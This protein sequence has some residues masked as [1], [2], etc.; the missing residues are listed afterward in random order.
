MDIKSLIPFRRGP[1][2]SQSQP[3]RSQTTDPFLALRQEMNRTFDDFFAGMGFPLLG[4]QPTGG[5]MALLTP[6]M[7]VSETDKDIRVTVEL[8]GLDADDIDIMV[9]DDVLT[10]RGEK[11]AEREED[12]R[13]YHVIERSEG[14]FA[15]SIRL[16]F[17]IDP[18]QMQ[19]V[20]RD[21]VLTITIPKPAEAQEKVRRVEVQRE[22]GA[23]GGKKTAVDRAAAG[24]KP[25]SAGGKPAG[26]AAK[27]AAQ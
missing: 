9:E 23:A 3:Q 7:D 18:E 6:Q 2:V 22:E 17:E 4:A 25:S 19:A 20:F 15:R 13:D 10:I 26:S 27:T 12:E 1:S 21:G 11:T 14:A 5:A 24:D 8:P 16:P